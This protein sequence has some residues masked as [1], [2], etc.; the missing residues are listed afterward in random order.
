MRHFGS[1]R[2]E[3][4]GAAVVTLP[5]AAAASARALRLVSRS[6][7]LRLAVLA[8]AA[9]AAAAKEDGVHIGNETVFD[10]EV[11]DI[12]WFGK[13]KNTLLLQTRTGMLHRSTDHGEAWTD[14]MP[15]LQ[16]LATAGAPSTPRGTIEAEGPAPLRVGMLARSRA[17][18]DIVLALPATG[19]AAGLMS[20]DAGATWRRIALENRVRSWIFH[21]TRSE[22]ALTSFWNEFCRR[23]LVRPEKPCTHDLYITKNAGRSFELVATRV[24]QFSW[25]PTESGQQDTILMTQFRGGEGHQ[26][27]LTRWMTGIDLRQT[28]DFGQTVTTLLQDGNK[29]QISNNYILVVKVLEESKQAITLMVS[30]D[31]GSN[32]K[33]ARLPHRLQ[34]RSYSLL[35]TSEGAVVLHVNHGYE[36]GDVYISDAGGLEFTLSV[37]GNIR[38]QGVCAFEKVMGMN[39]IYVANVAE[40][41]EATGAPDPAPPSPDEGPGGEGA[42]TGSQHMEKSIRWRRLED[43]GQDAG[44]EEE[45]DAGIVAGLDHD[46]D[47]AEGAA[48]LARLDDLA[49]QRRRSKAGGPR[50]ARAAVDDAESSLARRLEAGAAEP[51]RTVISFDKGGAWTTLRAPAVDLEG[52]AVQCETK[53]CHLHLHAFTDLYEF[54]PIYSYR[55]AVGILMGSG[56]V[57]ESLSFDRRVTNTY[58]SRNGGLTWTEVRKGTFIYEYGNHGGLVIIASMGSTTTAAAYSFDEGNSWKEVALGEPF[59]VTNVLIEPGATAKKFVVYGLRGDKGILHHMDF[60]GLHERTCQGIGDDVGKE[61]SDYEYWSP[62]D[63]GTCILGH[64]STYVR[65]KQTALCHNDEGLE[66]PTYTKNCKCH[67]DNFECNIGFQRSLNSKECTKDPNARF[68][69]HLN[70]GECSSGQFWASPYR[71]VP[72]DTCEG[73]FEPTKVLVPCTPDALKAAVHAMFSTAEMPPV[74]EMPADA[75]SSGSIVAEFFKGIASAFVIAGVMY[76]AARSDIVRKSGIFDRFWWS[77][78]ASRAGRSYAESRSARVGAEMV[79]AGYAPP[80]SLSV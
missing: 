31:S 48:V 59:S 77:M 34:H 70:A 32:F 1:R 38:K 24:V 64:K 47:H 28:G 69:G 65:R 5:P 51:I 8:C 75:G 6:R 17:D 36:V 73:G 26:P 50:G 80:P 30:S 66:R 62:T 58:L 20:S 61:S 52:K 12:Q 37:K 71:R 63:E 2:P 41:P 72:G 40:L 54:A 16:E 76:C 10:A 43:A 79:G 35:D 9:S 57:G 44:R 13:D 14:V 39:G 7:M 33:E 60:S 42:S 46:D 29:F 15:K 21:A 67:R 19:L 11:L 56:N 49:R 27:R 78:R 4:M 55:N 25:G 22:W 53:T 68:Y 74:A 3:A 23:D 45:L 18:P